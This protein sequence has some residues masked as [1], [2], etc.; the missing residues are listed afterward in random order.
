MFSPTSSSF[1]I[2]LSYLQAREYY[3]QGEQPGWFEDVNP[4]SRNNEASDEAF[5]RF[6]RHMAKSG[7]K[8][9]TIYVTLNSGGNIFAS[10]DMPADWTDAAGFYR[11]STEG[12]IETEIE[13]E[14]ER[15]KSVW[16]RQRQRP[17][18][19][20]VSIEWDIN[21]HSAAATLYS[22]GRD[23]D[24]IYLSVVYNSGDPAECQ[25]WLHKTAQRIYEE[26]KREWL[27]ASDGREMNLRGE[28]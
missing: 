7:I 25:Q 17:I 18:P 3:I 24:P 22:P 4:Y 20:A 23:F 8:E 21:A 14:A 16:K 11:Q 9:V 5:R 26:L 6:V 13:T 12:E 15:L 19:A 1:R 28:D 2:T 10:Q 27:I